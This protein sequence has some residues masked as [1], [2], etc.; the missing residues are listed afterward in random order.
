MDSKV[1]LFGWTLWIDLPNL[2][3]VAL[4]VPEIIGGTPKNL[5]SPW[6]RPHSL[7]SPTFKGLLLGWTL[8]TYLPT[9]KFVALGLR[10]PEIIGGTKKLG[11]LWIRPHSLF[12][13]IFSRACVWMDPVNIP[14]KYEVPIF[15]SSWDNNDCSFGVGLRTPNLREGDGTVR[16]SVCDF[17]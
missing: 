12:S 3:F 5:D 7:F 16:K 10:V 4:P 11:R 17:L 13:K 8:W 6:I 14:A 9:L 2:K 15:S 1:L